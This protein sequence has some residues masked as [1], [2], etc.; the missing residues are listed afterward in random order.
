MAT[1]L[2]FDDPY[3]L[4]FTAR[5]TRRG[6]HGG[7]PAVALDR[8]AFYPEGGGQ[9]ADHGTLGGA[10]V[11]DVQAEGDT[12]W[13]VVEGDAPGEEAEGVVDWGRRFDHMQQHH[14]QHLLSA[15]FEELFGL[16]TL[17]FHLGAEYASI[18]LPGEV[19]EEQ[20]RRAE[21]RANQVIW[22]DHEV[23]A[24]FV[25]PE[26]LAQLPLRKPPVVE[27]EVRVVSVAH[28][29]HSACGGTHPRRT[30]EVGLLHVRRREK[31]GAETRVEFLCGARALA[32]LR[33]KTGV[34]ARLSA[35]L[36]VGLDEIE[37]AVA[38]T[39]ERESA[40]RKR[41][42]VLTERLLESDAAELAARARAGGSRV[43][44]VV[45]A[46]LD[47]AGARGLAQAIARAGAVA[48]VGLRAEKPQLILV[49]PEG[50]PVDCAA[51]VREVL[52]RAGGK[53]GGQPAVAQGGVPDAALVDRVVAEAEAAAL[54]AAD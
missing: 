9:P 18:D 48:V 12:V 38:R 1:R 39:R 10:R 43:V 50:S 25:T 27:G 49:R 35:D 14:G 54:R 30:G 24:R 19:S 26:A 31:R 53:G 7:R 34:L 2:Y 45:R 11:V 4:R 20:I 21:A 22:E 8:T 47:A 51:I 32:D 36:S 6:E 28:F 23:H 29:D 46:D 16:P 13:H 5:I 37:E 42:A 41:L 15:A 17:A 33:R 52:S 44:A 3:L 40:A